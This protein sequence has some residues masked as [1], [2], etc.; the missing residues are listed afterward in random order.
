MGSMTGELAG[1]KTKPNFSTNRQ[2]T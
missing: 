1:K 2:P